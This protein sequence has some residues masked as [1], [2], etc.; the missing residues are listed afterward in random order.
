MKSAMIL[1]VHALE[2]AGLPTTLFNDRSGRYLPRFRTC[3]V[4]SKL[5]K[6]L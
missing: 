3:H 5:H 1:N 2:Q 4:I 6:N